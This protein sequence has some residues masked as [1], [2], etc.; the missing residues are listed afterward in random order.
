MK[1]TNTTVSFARE[2]L[3][4]AQ[5]KHL[6]DDSPSVLPNAPGFEEHRHDQAIYSLLVYK[7]GLQL[8]LEDQTDPSY[9]VGRLKVI[10]AARGKNRYLS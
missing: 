1:K 3:H 2:W 4:Y 10:F 6:I 8:V 5:Q 7:Y 9:K